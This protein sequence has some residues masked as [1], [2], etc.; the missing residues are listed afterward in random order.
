MKMTKMRELSN[1]P[2]RI[3]AKGCFEL[4][5][6]KQILIIFI[7]GNYACGSILPMVGMLNVLR[8]L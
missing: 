2:S 6:S 8:R 4:A 3:D 5:I 1:E 7:G